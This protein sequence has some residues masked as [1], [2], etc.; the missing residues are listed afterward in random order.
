MIDLAAG[1]LPHEYRG[2]GTSLI[3]GAG[4]LG[5]VIGFFVMGETISR[6][7]FDACLAALAITILVGAAFFA[8]CRRHA[9][10]RKTIAE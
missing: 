2:V 10:F 9:V 1:R 4:D 7:G 5:N 3:L 6:F 8:Y